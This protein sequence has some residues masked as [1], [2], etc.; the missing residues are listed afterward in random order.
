VLRGDG[1]DAHEKK[2]REKREN[3]LESIDTM[4]MM[5]SSTSEGLLMYI[6]S[7]YYNRVRWYERSGVVKEIYAS[8]LCRR[9]RKNVKKNVRKNELKDTKNCIEGV[10]VPRCCG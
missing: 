2:K 3:T 4:T 9:C 1:G 7:L 5:L 8:S 6:Q 10:L